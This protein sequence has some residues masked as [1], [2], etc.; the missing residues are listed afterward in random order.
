MTISAPTPATI[1]III[2]LSGSIST[3]KPDLYEPPWIHV[4]AVDRWWRFDG[5]RSRRPM[6]DASAPPKAT[7]QAPVAMKPVATR[8]SRVPASVITIAPASGARRQIQAPAIIYE[9]AVI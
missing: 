5:W 2:T 1:N 3:E 8:D 4:H 9:G 6:N 7:K